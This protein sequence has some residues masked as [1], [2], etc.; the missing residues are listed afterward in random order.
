M[1][2]TILFLLLSLLVFAQLGISRG[3]DDGFETDRRKHDHKKGRGIKGGDNLRMNFYKHSCP[4]AEGIVKRITWFYT[5]RNPVMGAKLLRLH[6][7]DCFVRGCDASI[8]LDRTGDD[9]VEKEARPNLSVTGYSVID[10]I[11]TQIENEC[12]GVVSCADIVA[13]AARDAVSFR[14]QQPLWQVLTGRR[15]G[16]VS[17]ASE[18]SANLPSPFGDFAALMD[19]FTQKGLDLT[20]LVALSGAHTIGRAHCGA[21]V[22]RLYNFTENGEADPSL[23]PEYADELRKSCPITFNPNTT[24]EMDDGDSR[25]FNSHYYINLNENKGLFQSD[26]A[27]LTNEESASEAKQLE[28]P[29]QFFNQFAK[30][31]VRMGAMEVLTG[32]EGEIRE[33]CSVVNPPA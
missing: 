4:L 11:K 3:D 23:D 27:L 22:K 31:M 9:P 2:S 30:S 14:F 21:V 15:D 24:L 33:R 25:V 16:N 18:A 8:L 28:K 5:S 26:A 19:M 17:L 12:P 1:K 10:A 6:Y 29:E 7:H 20:D 13:L 32:D